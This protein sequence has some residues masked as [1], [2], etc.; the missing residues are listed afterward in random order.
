[1]SIKTNIFK[2]V[3]DTCLFRIEDIDFESDIVKNV[4]LLNYVM[5]KTLY[6]IVLSG[7]HNEYVEEDADGSK[8]MSLSITASDSLKEVMQLYAELVYHVIH[9][10]LNTVVMNDV[11]IELVKNTVEQLRENKKKTLISFYS[12]NDEE[13]QLQMLLKRMGVDAW[14]FTGGESKDTYVDMG[15]TNA[16]TENLSR[17]RNQIQDGENYSTRGYLGENHDLDEIPEDYPSQFVFE[18]VNEV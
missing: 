16:G 3:L 14:Y 1:M 15:Q 4:V 18:P 8:I 5:L 7:I 2:D 11:D 6:T 9:E 12:G 10:L 13:R 17:R